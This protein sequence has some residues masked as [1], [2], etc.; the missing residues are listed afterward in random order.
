[1]RVSRCHLREGD[2]FVIQPNEE[3]SFKVMSKG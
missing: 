2:L 1:M 3:I